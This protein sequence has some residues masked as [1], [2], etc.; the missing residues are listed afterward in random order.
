MPR[1]REATAAVGSLFIETTER[2]KSD[3]LREAGSSQL[4]LTWLG[5]AKLGLHVGY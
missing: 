5:K 2:G 3:G 4:S 1:G